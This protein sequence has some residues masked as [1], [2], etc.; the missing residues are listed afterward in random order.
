MKAII[1]VSED[2]SDFIVE[3]L[4]SFNFVSIEPI[5]SYKYDVLKGIGNAVEEMKLIKKGELTGK[6]ARELLNEL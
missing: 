6:P 2:K 4:S 5:S 1:E 3:L